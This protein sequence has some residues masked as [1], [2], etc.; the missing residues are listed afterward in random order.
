MLIREE[1]TPSNPNAEYF[2]LAS[3]D[4]D[5]EGG[6]TLAMNCGTVRGDNRLSPPR[7]RLMNGYGLIS[8]IHDGLDIR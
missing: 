6:C 8:E 3:R 5:F 1:T 2:T 7:L 4:G